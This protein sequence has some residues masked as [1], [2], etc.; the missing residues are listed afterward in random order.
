MRELI[1]RMG[2][3]GP[4]PPDEGDEY[5][6]ASGYAGPEWKLRPD[7]DMGKNAKPDLRMGCQV[8]KM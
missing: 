8:S 4:K 1:Q 7:P 2:F 6:G 3:C 5:L